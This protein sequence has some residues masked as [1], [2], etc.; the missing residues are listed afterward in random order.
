MVSTVHQL[1]RGST[2]TSPGPAPAQ[3]RASTGDVQTLWD[4]LCEDSGVG[5]K[6]VGA[7]GRV[8]AINQPARQLLSLHRGHA[9][10]GE[11]VG[12]TL[13][14][15]FGPQIGAER[16]NTVHEALAS[17]HCIRLD[18]MI[19]GRMVRTLY[20][21]L[22]R[23]ASG[24]PAVV[25]TVRAATDVVP[26]V[27]AVMIRKAQ[28]HDAGELAKLTSRELEVLRFIGLG[29]STAEI[30]KRL[31]RSVKTI[32]W[33]RVALGEKLGIANR[34]ELARIAIAA[35][36]VGVEDELPI[37]AVI[38]ASKPAKESMIRMSATTRTSSVD[39]V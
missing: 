29:L 30:A 11:T 39:E 20:R 27:S 22:P 9:E 38:S 37:A 16:T 7:G 5:I 15:L 32:E 12:K 19:G 17:G 35:G 1:E 10:A 26:F 6:I 25:A 28:F 36:I 33:H 31:Q 14:E 13:L 4:A 8:M 24:D 23:R 34:V 3:W 21:P 18:G 2:G